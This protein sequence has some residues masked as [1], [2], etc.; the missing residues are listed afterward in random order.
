MKKIPRQNKQTFKEAI[1]PRKRLHE[2]HFGALGD[3]G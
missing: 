1:V 3:Y 2:V